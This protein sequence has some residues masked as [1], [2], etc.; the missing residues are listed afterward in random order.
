MVTPNMALYIWR[1]DL[2][3]MGA[4]AANDFPSGKG[5]IFAA[6]FCEMPFFLSR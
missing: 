4:A 6:V 3:T 5:H 2:C 1:G